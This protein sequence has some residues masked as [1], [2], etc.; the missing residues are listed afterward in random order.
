MVGRSGR[1]AC[2]S[3]YGGLGAGGGGHVV[4]VDVGDVGRGAQARAQP[5]RRV[6]RQPLLQVLQRGLEGAHHAQLQHT[7]LQCAAPTCP[8]SRCGARTDA[9]TDRYRSR[10]WCGCSLF[11]LRACLY[12]EFGHVCGGDEGTS[13]SWLRHAT[14]ETSWLTMRYR[15]DDDTMTSDSPVLGWRHAHSYV[16]QNKRT[17]VLRKLLSQTRWLHDWLTGDKRVTSQAG[18]VGRGQGRHGCQQH[19]WR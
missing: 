4:R 15:S 19:V 16:I 7:Q 14:R 13:T 12:S 11:D 5:R 9:R 8:A 18:R 17:K 1:C 3:E 6:R 2:R 10:V